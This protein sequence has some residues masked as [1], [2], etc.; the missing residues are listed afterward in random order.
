M[1]RVMYEEAYAPGHVQGGICSQAMCKEANTLG[2]VTRRRT[3]RA[4]GQGAN[5][6]GWEH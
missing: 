3:L 5:V 1:Y 4:G 6:L 2:L